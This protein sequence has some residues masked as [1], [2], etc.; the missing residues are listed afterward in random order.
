MQKQSIVIFGCGFLGQEVGEQLRRNGMELM[1][2]GDNYSEVA[3][4][5]AKDFQA[6]VVDIA[7][8]AALRNLG[9]G[10]GVRLIF[11]LF[12]E[13]S[14]NVF[15]TIAARA[16]DPSL[17]IVCITESADSGSKLLAAGASRVIDPYTMT[18]LKIHELIHRPWLVETLEGTLFGDANLDLAE[19]EVPAGV[20]LI[21]APMHLLD[22]RRDNNLILLGVVDRTRGKEMMFNSSRN[23][24]R[25][26]P[27]D[28]LVVI[29]LRDDIGRFIQELQGEA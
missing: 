18:A 2:I 3:A 26:Q 27:G 11:C 17:E 10:N 19:V 14:K 15:L 5:R 28:I 20:Q 1:L 7:D 22:L 25:I 13:E 21:G 24:H 29:G 6:N 16:L 8:D 9:I 23:A 12:P 4:A